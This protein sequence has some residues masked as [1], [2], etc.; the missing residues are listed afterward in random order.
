MRS[1]TEFGQL[2]TEFLEHGAWLDRAI[3]TAFVPVGWQAENG[4]RIAR[5]Q[6]ANDHVVHI[7]GI[8]DNSPLGG[9]LEF[10]RSS[11]SPLRSMSE[12]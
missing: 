4:A 1:V 7:F 5:A 11:A 2:R 10:S 9:E 6:R 12:A 8:L 3:V